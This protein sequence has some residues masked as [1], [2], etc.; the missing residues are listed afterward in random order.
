MAVLAHTT[1]AI[2]RNALAKALAIQKVAQP[3]LLH[4]RRIANAHAT[5]HA[6]ALRQPAK[7]I[8]IPNTLAMQIS[9]SAWLPAKRLIPIVMQHATVGAVEAIPQAHLRLATNN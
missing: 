2:K 4:A 3:T 6:T 5:I 8:V 9:I 7:Q 1:V